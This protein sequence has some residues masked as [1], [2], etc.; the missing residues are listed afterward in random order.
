MIVFGLLS[1]VFD[2]ITFATLVNIF[3]ASESLFQSAW[4]IVSLLTELAVV[5][6][7][8]TRRPSWRSLPGRLLVGLTVAVAVVAISLPYLGVL[9][10]WF[11]L[12]PLPPYLLLA[13]VTVVGVYVIANEVAKRWFYRRASSMPFGKRM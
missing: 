12:V 11:G 8:R 13:G 7:L 4:F 9:S 5:L 3:H 1:T 10:G 2:L 6:V